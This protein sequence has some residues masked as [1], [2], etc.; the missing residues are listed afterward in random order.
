MTR[1]TWSKGATK[2]S[3]Q[4]R[5]KMESQQKWPHDMRL[6]CQECGTITNH[7]RGKRPDIDGC[8][9]LL[10]GDGP[11]CVACLKDVVAFARAKPEEFAAMAGLRE[12]DGKTHPETYNRVV[13][14]VFRPDP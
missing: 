6:L 12:V 5:A 10:A 1:R 3:H 13:A 11:H 2:L 14:A 8:V 9:L 4:S 7:V